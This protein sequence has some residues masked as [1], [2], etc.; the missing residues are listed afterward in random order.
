M[1][2][3]LQRVILFFF[4]ILI[5]FILAVYF[6]EINNMK[7][8]RLEYPNLQEEAFSYRKDNLK[9]WGLNLL[10]T[11]LIP[12]FFLISGLSDKISTLVGCKKG[13]FQSGLFYGLIF[14]SLIFFINLPLNFY[15]SYILPH[16]YGLSAQSFTRWFEVNIKGFLI[17]DLI[18][19]LFLWIPYRIIYKHPKTWW[20][21]IALIIMPIMI[22][23]SFISP[24]VIDPIFN[25]YISIEEDTLGQ[26]IEGLLLKAGIDEAGIYRVDKSKDTKTMNAYMTGIFDSKRIVLWDT[27][28]HNLEK[29]EVLSITAHEIGH[30]VKGHIWKSI[31]ISSIS[32]FLILYLVYRLSTWVLKL[33]NG[34]FGFK[35]LS[36]Y[37]SIPLLVITLSLFSFL[38]N[39]ISNYVSRS[40]EMEA[41]RYEISLT[42][43]RESAVSA[44]K[45]L[46]KT[47][48][49]LPR[50]STIYKIWYHTHPTLEERVDFYTRAGFE[51]IGD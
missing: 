25:E 16:K 45:K 28:I 27:T 37:A 40:M 31:I 2:K 49:G 39:P 12:L 42:E 48:L 36:T 44:M 50:S 26:E 29:D 10:L 4:A 7:D 30:Y 8:L 21:K 23:T 15:S 14:F 35:D 22:L 19:S 9:V 1:N 34:V 32:T 24:L 20:F 46:T 43:D 18:T 47:S 51:R 38:S 41:D 6:A 33:S 3:K 17:N 13:S 11:F 5:L